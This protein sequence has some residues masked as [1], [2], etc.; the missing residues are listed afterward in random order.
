MQV[1]MADDLQ[2]EE[3]RRVVLLELLRAPADREAIE[4]PQRRR[5]AGAVEAEVEGP[6]RR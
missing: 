6:E 5:S 2:R 4:E 3:A 1:W